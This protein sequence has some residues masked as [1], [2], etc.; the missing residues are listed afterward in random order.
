M[1]TVQPQPEVFV[2]RT[3]LEEAIADSTPGSRRHTRLSEALARLDE[4][5]RIAIAGRIKA[6]KSTLLN[7]L[8]GEQL[9][10]TDAGE[11][12]RVVTWYVAS[13]IPSVTVMTR[14]GERLPQPVR[15]V[16]GRL[17]L[18]T[19]GVPVEDI[20]RIEVGWPSP[21]LADMTLV[22]TPG[23][24]S[25]SEEVSQRST[26]ALLPDDSASPVDAI[27]YLL[28]HLHAADAEFL[29][30]VGG[31]GRLG[32]GPATTLGV[33]SR[34]DE[35]GG[36][37]I[38]SLIA[39]ER[40]AQRY[41]T[42][43]SVRAL[44]LDVLPVAGLMAEGGRTLRQGEFAALVELSRL[45]RRAREDLLVAADR[46]VATPL[47]GMAA[48]TP[49]M[50][51]RLLDRFGVFGIRLAIVLVRDGFDSASSLADELVRRSGMVH[52]TD[53]VMAQFTARAEGLKSRSALVALRR[54]TERGRDDAP[55]TDADA[56][57]NADTDDELSH[58]VRRALLG[59]HHPEEMML[60]ATLRSAIPPGL[61]EMLG[62][63]AERIIG[64]HGLSAATRLGLGDSAEDA[65]VRDAVFEQVATWRRLAN[66]P[67]QDQPV[68]DTA[69]TVIRSL[70]GVLASARATRS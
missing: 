8:L 54:E 3:L 16:D 35:V 4:P 58:R 46:F 30:D 29:R 37:R 59:N 68:R 23:L 28:R 66:D 69:T 63:A 39:A 38:D 12:T 47:P 25:L 33:L 32:A 31:E 48:A 45:D 15:R 20:D 9:A 56:E 10:P 52:L 24:A 13:D 50:R 44:C 21:V 11:C 6:G 61:S 27:V 51:R 7:A 26:D 57:A 70:E 62:Q 22:D 41:R 64:G 42:D 14:S 60:L 2:A 49:E 1:T 36:G 17:D 19:G 67:V 65:E 53:Y 5:V 34:A 55:D 18:D 40:V 43:P